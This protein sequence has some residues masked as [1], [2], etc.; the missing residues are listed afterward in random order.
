[1]Q[2]H[3]SRRYSCQNRRSTACW[4]SEGRGGS[5]LQ[6]TKILQCHATR[7]AACGVQLL[8][9]HAHEV[10]VGQPRRNG[11]EGVQVRR[12][13][14]V[15]LRDEVEAEQGEPAR[16]ESTV[17]GAGGDDTGQ[18]YRNL[19]QVGCPA[20]SLATKWLSGDLNSPPRPES[21]GHLVICRYLRDNHGACQGAF[22]ALR[23][24]PHL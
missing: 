19:L 11:D 17:Q 6:G 18:A 9:A 14:P 1:M 3:V 5:R 7:L 4:H 23:R 13:T 12:R 8:E 24:R 15:Q 16:T 10:L 21:P 2:Q 20:A 22:S